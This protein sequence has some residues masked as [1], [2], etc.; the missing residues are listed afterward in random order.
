VIAR[1]ERREIILKTLNIH[2][3][4]AATLEVSPDAKRSWPDV[5][6]GSGSVIGVIVLEKGTGT[7]GRAVTVGLNVERNGARHKIVLPK[8]W[9]NRGDG[10]ARHAASCWA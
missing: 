4:M 10:A 5:V 6:K 3:S 1:S 2:G 8:I 9:K 7:P